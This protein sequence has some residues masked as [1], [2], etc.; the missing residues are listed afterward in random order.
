MKALAEAWLMVTD[1]DPIPLMKA[2]PWLT[3]PPVGLA[4]TSSW[5][6]N[7]ASRSNARSVVRQKRRAKLYLMMRFISDPGPN[8]HIIPSGAV[9]IVFGYI[10][11]NQNWAVM[12]KLKYG[13]LRGVTVVLISGNENKKL[14]CQCDPSAAAIPK[15][16]PQSLVLDGNPWGSSR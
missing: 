4:C 16:V 2:L 1:D 10:H 5:Q 11:V 3:E 15:P 9:K 8:T 6:Q 12:E 13:S 14:A 7:E